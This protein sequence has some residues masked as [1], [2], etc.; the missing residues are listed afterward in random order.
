MAEESGNIRIDIVD[1]FYD[2]LDELINKTYE[3]DNISYGEIELA[4]LKM[5]DKI[6]Q[7][8][9]TLMHQYLHSEDAINPAKGKKEPSGVYG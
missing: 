1:K 4:F 3:E 6:L 7:Q 8:K 2:S 9:I 5:D